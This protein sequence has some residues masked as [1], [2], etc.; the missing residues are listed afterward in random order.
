MLENNQQ[1]DG[2]INVPDVP[3][4]TT[5]EVTPAFP[6]LSFSQPTDLASAPGD[7]QAVSVLLEA[8]LEAR[9]GS[10]RQLA[11]T[12]LARLGAAAGDCR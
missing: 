2:S 8:A 6:G 3:P 10:T 5:I 4:A 9:D 11:L 7:A 1:A 12:S